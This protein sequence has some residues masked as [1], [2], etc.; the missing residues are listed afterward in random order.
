MKKIVISTMTGLIAIGL[1]FVL[2]HLTP[3]MAL[4]THVFFMGYPIA[5]ITSAIVNDEFHNEMYKKEFKEK[6]SKAFTL[7]DPP[8]E[9]ASQGQLRNFKVTQVGYLNFADYLGNF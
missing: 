5:A 6:N 9:K 3:K 7:T 8:I 4:R 2:L 1:L